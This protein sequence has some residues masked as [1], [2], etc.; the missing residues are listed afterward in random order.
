M[1]LMDALK[2]VIGL[3]QFYC[4]RHFIPIGFDEIAVYN[5]VNDNFHCFKWNCELGRY[6]F[7]KSA[8]NIPNWVERKIGI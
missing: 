4:V 6:I 8:D 7:I 3:C 5:V 1:S 2:T